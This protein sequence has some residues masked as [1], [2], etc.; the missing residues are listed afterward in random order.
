M[1]GTFAEGLGFLERP[2]ADTGTFNGIGGALAPNV[3]GLAYTDNLTIERQLRSDAVAK[4]DG[5]NLC[6]NKPNLPHNEPQSRP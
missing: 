5:R 1:L 2:F 6:P 3:F 4:H